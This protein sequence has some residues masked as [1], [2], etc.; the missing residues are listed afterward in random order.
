MSGVTISRV[1]PTSEPLALV[2]VEERWDVVLRR[3]YLFKCTLHYDLDTALRLIDDIEQTEGWSFVGVTRESFFRFTCGIASVDELEQI[4][5]GYAVMRGKGLRTGTKE[6]ALAYAAADGVGK[7]MAPEGGRPR[8]NQNLAN[9]Y[10]LPTG[11]TSAARIVARLKR[12]HP[13]I[14][15][16]LAAGE[17]RSARAA[18]IEA[19]LVVPA[20]PLR[21]VR[22]AWRRATT[23]EREAI[24]AWVDEQMSP[25][26]NSRF[27][28]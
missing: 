13:D 17:F 23:E 21:V 12:D 4:R 24:A 25:L 26:A 3:G 11:S 28:A 7:A 20:T 9:S 10:V 22:S 27:V 15:E 5:A 6:Q 19:G 14:A 16:R 1:Y 8:D 2:P 18:A